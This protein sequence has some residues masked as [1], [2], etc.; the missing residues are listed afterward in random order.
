MSARSP[1]RSPGVAT[2]RRSATSHDADLRPNASLATPPGMTPYRPTLEEFAELAGRGNTVPVYLQLLSDDLTPVSAF[3][4][5]ADRT[6]HAFLLESVIGGEQIARY[7]FIAAEPAAMFE[8]TRDRVTITRDGRTETQTSDDPL[9]L[10][11]ACLA[12]YRAVHLPELP[13]FC[14]GAVGYAGYDAVRYVE[15]LPDAPPDDRGLPD[16][17]FGIYDRMVI[18]DHVSKTSNVVCE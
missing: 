6:D 7:S 17:S 13:R 15:H 2:C 14:G 18:F 16:L 5:V 4:R 9:K 3:A 11:E 1:A 8:A 10:L 12:D